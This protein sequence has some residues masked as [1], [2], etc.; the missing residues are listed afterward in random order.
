MNPPQVYMLPQRRV[1]W[2]WFGAFP[3]AFGLPS[4]VPV[5]GNQPLSRE[6]QAVICALDWK[7]TPSTRENRVRPPSGAPQD[8]ALHLSSNL[9]EGSKGLRSPLESHRVFLGPN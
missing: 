3:C 8:G 5:Q 7:P 2:M 1:V 4:T 6:L 9:L